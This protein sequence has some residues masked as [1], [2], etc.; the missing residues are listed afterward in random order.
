MA[1]RL[2]STV[3][4]SNLVT[5]D[6]AQTLRNKVFSTADNALSGVDLTAI[7]GTLSVTKGGLGT[8]TLPAN[9]LLVGN[10]TGAVQHIAPGASG[11]VLTSNGSAWTAVMP[12]PLDNYVNVGN[13][14]VATAISFGNTVNEITLTAN[15]ALTFTGATS[16]TPA[17][18]TLIVKQD[19]TGG[20]TITWP[21]TA[22]YAGGVAPP[23]ST[24]A[25]DID[26][27]SIFTVDGGTTLFVSLAVKDAG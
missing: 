21:L 14:G 5:T 12:A 8:T 10:G 3:A 7:T 2:S 1:R 9:N 24:G 23:Q 27:W 20:R 26:I 6:G 16:G 25:N 4:P 19:A 11:A 22:K 13:V 15:V 18:T 17:S